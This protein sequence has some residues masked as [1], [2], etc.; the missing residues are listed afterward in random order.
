MQSQVEEGYIRIRI[1]NVLVNRPQYKSYCLDCEGDRVWIAKKCC[2]L[3]KENMTVDI[4]EWLYNKL[5]EG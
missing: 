4:E 3:D 2:E 1:N 5:F